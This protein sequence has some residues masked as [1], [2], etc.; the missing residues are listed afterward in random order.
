MEYTIKT[1]AET[2]LWG[3]TTRLKRNDKIKI[4]EFWQYFSQNNIFARIPN[5][6]SP[7]IVAMYTN[8]N[9]ENEECHFWLGGL[10]S[11]ANKSD[12]L[13]KY[14]KI[15]ELDYAVFVSRGIP[16]EVLIRIWTEIKKTNLD[17]NYFAD[18]EIYKPISDGLFEVQVYV[19][20][21]PNLYKN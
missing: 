19:S 10:V 2:T 20:L 13:L 12:E 3:V 15:P 8:Q 21:T 1:M 14:K 16:G 7:R 9:P 6:L 5:L 18:F 4:S 11:E 17:R